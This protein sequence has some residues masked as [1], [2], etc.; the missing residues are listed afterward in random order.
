M[1]DKEVRPPPG[2]PRRLRKLR[3][4]HGYTQKSLAEIVGVHW[5]TIG[6]WETGLHSPPPGDPII[7]AAVALN[8]TVKYLLEGKR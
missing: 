6:H 8:T 4:Q 5:R 3:L 1:V 7:R 2:F